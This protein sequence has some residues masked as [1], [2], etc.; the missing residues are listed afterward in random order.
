MSLE[1]MKATME[2]F[3]GATFYGA[4]W[5]IDDNGVPILKPVTKMNQEGKLVLL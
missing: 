4:I 3:N 2:L 5:V 1:A